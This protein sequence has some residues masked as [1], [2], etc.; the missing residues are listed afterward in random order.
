MIKELGHLN[1]VDSPWFSVQPNEIQYINDNFKC[2]VCPCA[3]A[4]R[5]DVPYLNYLSKNLDGITIPIVIMGIGAEDNLDLNCDNDIQIIESLKNLSSRS[6]IGTRGD[7]TTKVLEK[8]GITNAM[9]I[10]CP[11]LFSPCSKK[12]CV[13]SVNGTSNKI[14][15]NTELGHDTW[16]PL[17]YGNLEQFSYFP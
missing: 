14:A 8:Y 13:G 6:I 10:G 3:N 17:Y 16:S 5:H 2:V 9:T 7:F 1:C 11:S 15:F 12:F 4:F